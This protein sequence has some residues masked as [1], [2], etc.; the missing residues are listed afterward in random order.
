MVAS[1][2]IVSTPSS[3]IFRT[4]FTSQCFRGIQTIPSSSKR[5]AHRSI[6]IRMSAQAPQSQPQPPENAISGPIKG[7]YGNYYITSDDIDEVTRYRLSLTIMSFLQAGGLLLSSSGLSIPQFLPDILFFLSTAAFGVALQ[8]IHIYAKPL[9]NFLKVLWASGLFGAVVI[10]LKALTLGETMS[11]YALWHPE[12]MLALGWQFVALTGLFVK[13]A[14]CYG[15]KQAYALIAVTPV[16]CL[17]H[18]FGIGDFKQQLSAGF[19]YASLFIYFCALKL[20]QSPAEDLGDLSVF[21][22]LATEREKQ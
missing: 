15:E 6:F 21:Q 11:S 5:R 12:A 18:L 1:A 10:F 7:M 8:N 16:V 17:A 22:Y 14:I 2:F 13:E 4:S 3:L 20:R 19:L 9:H